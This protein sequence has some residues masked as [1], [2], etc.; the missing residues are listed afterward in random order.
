MSRVWQPLAAIGL[1]CLSATALAMPLHRPMPPL[2][3]RGPMMGLHAMVPH[4]RRHRPVPML[5]PLAEM[6]SDALHLDDHQV[7]A[8]AVWRNQHMRVAIPLIRRL[9]A[10]R[11]ALRADLTGGA[12]KGALKD[13]LHRLDSDRARM[14]RLK[15][16]QVRMVRKTLSSSQW[17]KL[18][19]MYRRMHAWGMRGMPH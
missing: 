3:P 7:S 6:G 5:L 8:L 11:S 12:R 2:G 19:L 4:P 18:L 9:R 1:L 10:D 15:V 14:L 13:I 17:R 16:A